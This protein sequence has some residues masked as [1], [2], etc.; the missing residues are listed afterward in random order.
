MVFV[1]Y[2]N[3]FSKVFRPDVFKNLCINSNSDE[4][5]NLFF[6][7]LLCVFTYKIAYSKSLYI[8]PIIVL[9]SNIGLQ[10][11]LYS[12][13][14]QFLSLLQNGTVE[15]ATA[16][17]QSCS[18]LPGV[19]CYIYGEY[20]PNESRLISVFVKTASIRCF[21][22]KLVDEDKSWAPHIVCKT[23]SEHLHQ[24]P[25]RNCLKYGT[26]TVRSEPENNFDDLLLL[27]VS[28]ASIE[29]INI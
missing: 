4:F 25:K 28:Q 11:E 18:N 20:T 23:C 5:F 2:L 3:L 15:A 27:S 14:T 24:R 21:C 16:S 29:M 22:V 10:R 12:P 17:R 6:C 7:Y 9:Q 8:F 19:F 1:N 26:P 13:I